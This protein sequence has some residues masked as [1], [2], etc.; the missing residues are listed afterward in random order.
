MTYKRITFASVPLL[1]QKKVWLWARSRL[2]L[3]E[4]RMYVETHCMAFRGLRSVGSQVFQGKQLGDRPRGELPDD[5]T[6]TPQSALTDTPFQLIKIVATLDEYPT[7]GSWRCLLFHGG[8]LRI[9]WGAAGAG[10]CG[11]PLGRPREAW[12]WVVQKRNA[13]V[14]Q[15]RNPTR[16]VS[17]V[18]GSSREMPTTRVWQQNSHHGYCYFTLQFLR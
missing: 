17:S 16:L 4:L 9:L 10:G 5:G 6:C 7:W 8:R 14:N 3:R 11:E 1:C 12:R 13:E 2:S 18:L 15:V